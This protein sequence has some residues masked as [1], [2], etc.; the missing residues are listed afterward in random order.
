[1]HYNKNFDEE[2]FKQLTSEEIKFTKNKRGYLAQEY[3]KTRD[4]NEALDLEVYNLAGIKLLQKE[5]LL[6]LSI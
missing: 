6:D 1:M 5:N 3:V 4:R 2:Y